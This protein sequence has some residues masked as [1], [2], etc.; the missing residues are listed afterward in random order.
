M[1]VMKANLMFFILTFD[2]KFVWTIAKLFT[3][4][5]FICMCDTDFPN[6]IK[7]FS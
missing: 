5:N 3:G 4:G 6:L 1:I 7:T 2:N